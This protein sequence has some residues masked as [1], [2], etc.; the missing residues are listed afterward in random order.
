MHIILQ[1]GDYEAQCGQ[2]CIAS[3]GTGEAVEGEIGAGSAG[4]V[5]IYPGIMLAGIER[6]DSQ[7]RIIAI[8]E[9]C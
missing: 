4:L 2:L 5:E 1:I 7:G 6:V 8:S 3:R 9:T